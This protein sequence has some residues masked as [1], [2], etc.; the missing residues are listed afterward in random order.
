V[1][2]TTGALQE[3]P[4][5][6]ERETM[7]WALLSARG[8]HHATNQLAPPAGANTIELGHAPGGATN[9]A[10]AATPNAGFACASIARR[11]PAPGALGVRMASRHLSGGR[12]HAAQL[13]VAIASTARRHSVA[14]S[15]R[16]RLE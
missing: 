15:M 9:G 10:V 4:P 12:S 13:A 8:C 2:A 14:P 3:P 16:V 6:I 5:L 1:S 7:S 11:Q